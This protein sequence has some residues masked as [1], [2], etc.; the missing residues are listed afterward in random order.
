[1]EVVKTT[2]ATSTNLDM[3]NDADLFLE[4]YDLSLKDYLINILTV[5]IIEYQKRMLYL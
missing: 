5:C 3:R 1:M 4:R 2:V